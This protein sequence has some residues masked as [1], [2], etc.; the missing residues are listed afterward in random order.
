MKANHRRIALIALLIIALFLLAEVL[1]RN[2]AFTQSIAELLY[3]TKHYPTAEKVFSRNAAKGDKVASANLAKSLYQ[4]QRYGDAQS[5]SSEALSQDDDNAALNYDAGNIAYKQGDFQ[6][7]LEH[8]RKALLKNPNDKDTKANYE[9]ALRKL[10][11]Q[12]PP[13]QDEKKDEK[14]QEDIRN[15]LG[16]LDNKESSDR[17]QQS[18]KQDIPPDKWW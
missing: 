15:I 3:R 7:A 11:Q 9:L 8:Y 17:K 6:S 2:K 12:P 14:Q 4:Q 1:L 18:L 5:P 10:Q 16:G 13:K